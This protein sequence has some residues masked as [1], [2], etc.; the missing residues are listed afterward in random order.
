MHW[1]RISSDCKTSDM[2]ELYVGYFHI[3]KSIRS[4]YRNVSLQSLLISPA[5]KIEGTCLAQVDSWLAAF[6]Q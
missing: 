2:T 6:V 1:L 5:E 4:L 3:I